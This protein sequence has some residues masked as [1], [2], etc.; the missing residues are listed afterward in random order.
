[1]PLDGIFNCQSL[2]I[3]FPLPIPSRRIIHTKKKKEKEKFNSTEWKVS[4]AY[5]FP[6]K[7][8]FR[9]RKLENFRPRKVSFAR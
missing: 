4:V 1:M 3:A 5:E 2:E 8:N 6:W 9:Y 7:G